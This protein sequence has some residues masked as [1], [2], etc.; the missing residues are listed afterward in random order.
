MKRSKGAHLKPC[1]PHLFAL[2]L[3]A[4]LL[5]GLAAFSWR[6]DRRAGGSSICR[7][8]GAILRAPGGL[9]SGRPVFGRRRAPMAL[10]GL[11][12]LVL[13]L[14]GIAQSERVTRGGRWEPLRSDAVLV[15]GG[16]RF[17]LRTSR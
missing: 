6:C 9:G 7:G 15:G 8:G 5:G 11:I 4:G 16:G 17:A 12:L 10:S 14:I 3:D 2:F 1:L 13:V